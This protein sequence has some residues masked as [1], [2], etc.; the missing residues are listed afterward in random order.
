MAAGQDSFSLP[1]QWWPTTW[2]VANYREVLEN[3]P[4]IA[5]VVNSLQVT[6]LIT[7]GQLVTCS[8]A[9]YAFARLCFPGREPL[10]L[11][12]LSQLMVP[13]QVTIIPVFILTASGLLTRPGLSS[14]PPCSAR[15]DLLLRQ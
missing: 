15:R 2:H 10:F 13:Q 9:A 7:L 14:S 3:I 11:V 1:P 5:F 6:V 8:M 12:F 4:F